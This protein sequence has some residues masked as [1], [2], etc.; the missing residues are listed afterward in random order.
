MQNLDSRLKEAVLRYMGARM[1]RDK[2]LVAQLMYEAREMLLAEKGVDYAAQEAVKGYLE[3]G[4]L[5]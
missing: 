2:N 3:T 5:S 1:A 4:E